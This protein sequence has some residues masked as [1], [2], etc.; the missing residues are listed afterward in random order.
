MDTWTPRPFL[1]AITHGNR[2]INDFMP[3]KSIHPLC[4]YSCS[5]LAVESASVHSIIVCNKIIFTLHL[6][7]ATIVPSPLQ[8]L[9]EFSAQNLSKWFSCIFFLHRLTAVQ[10]Q[11][12]SF[13]VMLTTHA[14]F[15]K[16]G[17]GGPS[18]NPRRICLILQRIFFVGICLFFCSKIYIFD[19]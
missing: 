9:F 5:L 1:Y 6:H 19:S 11:Q 17:I 4:S 15:G 18:S 16:L 3:Q 14:I 7:W 8:D 10:E 12:K 13:L 2:Q